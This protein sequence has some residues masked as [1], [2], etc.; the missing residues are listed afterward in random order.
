MCSRK[1]GIKEVFLN[2]FSK[3]QQFGMRGE[4]V[5]NELLMIRIEK[6]SQMLKN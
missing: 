1:D 6:I 2:H 4:K 5:V 3:I